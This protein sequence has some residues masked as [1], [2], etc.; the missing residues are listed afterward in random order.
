MQR[1]IYYISMLRT[2]TKTRQAEWIL[3]QLQM[4][5]TGDINKAWYNVVWEQRYK[6]DEE[7]TKKY[8]PLVNPK[9]Y[10]YMLALYV[11]Y[12]GLGVLAKNNMVPTKMLIDTLTPPNI[13]YPW[14]RFKI[15]IRWRSIYHDD[16]V[17]EGF[18]YLAEKTMEYHPDVYE[19]LGV[20]M[21]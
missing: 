2:N 17:L 15:L 13:L 19:N 7:W 10:Q 21:G 1:A 16:T 14:T 20:L 8:G 9:A 18:Q 5:A 4:S 12:N 11:F 6:T 3:R